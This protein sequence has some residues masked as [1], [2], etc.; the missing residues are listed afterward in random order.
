MQQSVTAR[1][2]PGWSDRRVSLTGLA[3]VSAV[4]LVII[5]LPFLLSFVSI[6]SCVLLAREVFAVSVV[7]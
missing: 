2:G 4:M 1:G 6:N 5:Y 7:N 3:V